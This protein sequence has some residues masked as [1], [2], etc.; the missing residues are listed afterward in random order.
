MEVEEKKIHA[1]LQ[2]YENYYQHL[3]EQKDEKEVLLAW[4]T[5][6]KEDDANTREYIRSKMRKML[7]MKREFQIVPLTMNNWTKGWTYSFPLSDFEKA[8]MKEVWQDLEGKVRQLSASELINQKGYK[9]LAIPRL[10]H[11]NKLIFESSLTKTVD[12]QLH[13]LFYGKDFQWL[14]R[15][16][17]F[18]LVMES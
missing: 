12:Q 14:K 5:I 18:W 4:D 1:N 7:E 8:M 10:I 11:L 9:I 2:R 3:K 16:L 17:M 13:L 6:P 15:C